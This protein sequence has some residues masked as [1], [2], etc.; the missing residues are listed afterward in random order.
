M[1][2]SAARWTAANRPVARTPSPLVRTMSASVTRGRVSADA[3][4]LRG[5]EPLLDKPLLKAL[6]LSRDRDARVLESGAL[7]LPAAWALGVDDEPDTGSRGAGDEQPVR[8]DCYSSA[9]ADVGQ[10]AG[11]ARQRDADQD[12]QRRRRRRPG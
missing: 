12:A 3:R 7:V 11:H 5:L 8:F 10:A 1:A 9:G 4:H 2:R 6:V